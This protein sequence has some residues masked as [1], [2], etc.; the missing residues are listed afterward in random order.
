MTIISEAVKEGRRGSLTQ[1]RSRKDITIEILPR[2]LKNGEEC[3]NVS[4]NFT[5]WKIC[6]YGKDID[7]F[8]K[9]EEP[10]I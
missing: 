2:I 4:D 9:M 6:K 3:H 1:Q 5:G 7:F 8:K 10:T